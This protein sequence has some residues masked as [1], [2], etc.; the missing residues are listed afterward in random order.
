MNPFAKLRRV[1]DYL[2]NLKTDGATNIFVTDQSNIVKKLATTSGIIVASARPELST[3]GKLNQYDIN[4]VIF[5]IHPDLGNSGTDGKINDHYDR[6]GDLA[7]AIAMQ[8]IDN[9]EGSC[10][11]LR[12][13]SVGR[14]T[15][16]PTAS[17]FGGFF[18][19]II[20]I[21]LE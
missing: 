15:M 21:T 17:V 4:T 11:D 16:T 13:L 5:V 1:S 7:K 14:M 2:K 9:T 18:G 12:G 6:M 3:D 20:E 19:W 8:M 10:Q